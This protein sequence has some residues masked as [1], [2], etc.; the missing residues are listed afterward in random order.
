MVDRLQSCNLIACGLAAVATSL[1]A[2]TASLACGGGGI[3][4]SNIQA[5]TIAGMTQI[6]IHVKSSSAHDVDRA[7]L[8]GMIARERVRRQAICSQDPNNAKCF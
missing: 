1:G 5:A 8:L 4:L 6:E 3:G 7:K 2:S